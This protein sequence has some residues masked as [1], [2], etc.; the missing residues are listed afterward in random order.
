MSFYASSSRTRLLSNRSISATSHVETLPDV[1]PD[2]S[3]LIEE[4]N[5]EVGAVCIFVFITNS[6]AS[7]LYCLLLFN[8]LLL[9]H[10]VV[11]L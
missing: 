8:I 6:T 11:Y 10:G 1:V 3:Q 9:V 4:E 2:H 5:T 7:L